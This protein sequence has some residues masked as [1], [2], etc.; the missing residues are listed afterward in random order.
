[1]DFSW[2]DPT[3]ISQASETLDLDHSIS[4][5]N[6]YGGDLLSGQVGD[7]GDA[8]PDPMDLDPWKFDRNCLRFG[9]ILDRLRGCANLRQKV[10]QRRS[11]AE[12]Q[13]H[14]SRMQ[15]V[16]EFKRICCFDE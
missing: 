16:Q 4:S 6:V 11:S 10:L 8:E 5:V 1:M 7:M 2:F 3:P 13:S 9:V 12:A 15:M 14:L